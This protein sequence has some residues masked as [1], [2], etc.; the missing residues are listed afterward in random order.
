M[1]GEIGEDFAQRIS[2]HLVKAAREAKRNSNWIDP[3]VG[4]EEALTGF[5]RRLILAEPTARTLIEQTVATVER[6]G[7]VNSLGS[8]LLKATA[9]GVPDIYQGEDAWFQAL[10]DPD[11]RRPL[12]ADAHAR[13][14]ASLPRFGVECG[15]EAASLLAGWRTGAVKQLVLRNALNVRRDRPE[16]F[17]S[18]AYQPLEIIGAQRRHVVAFARVHEQSWAI[19]VVPRLVVGIAG[20]DRFPVGADIWPDT[21]IVVPSGCPERLVDGL[22]GQSIA[23]RDGRIAVAEALATLPVALLV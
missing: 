22:T 12:D 4:Y 14:L 13:L 5:A 9:P 1:D 23:S 7:V 18:G 11:N 15:A 19:S 17:A 2:E 20:P 16:L 10:V 3:A 6:A 21:E 8:V